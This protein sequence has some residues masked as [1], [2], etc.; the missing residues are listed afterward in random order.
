M[1]KER[2]RI[3]IMLVV[4]VG[5]LVA[6]AFAMKWFIIRAPI[7]PEVSQIGLDLRRVEACTSVGPCVTIPFKGT[8][9][10]MYPTFAMA[11]LWGSVLFGVLVGYQA[12]TRI[13]S[14]FA[15]EPLTKM[16]YMAGVSLISTAFMTGYLFAP[17]ASGTP[18]QSMGFTIEIERTWAPFMLIVAHGLGIAICFLA[19]SQSSDSGSDDVS[20]PSLPPARVLVP[21]GVSAAAAVLASQPALAPQPAPEPAPVAAMPEA[22]RGILKFA[23]IH[24]ELTAAGIDARR[25]DGSSELVMWRDVVGAVARQMPPEYDSVTFVDIVSTPGATVRVLPWT[26]LTGEPIEG[27]SEERA[28]ALLTLIEARCKEP[29]LDAATKAFVELRE[30]AAQLPDLRMLAIHDQRLGWAT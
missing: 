23:I 29:K 4:F 16:G 6:S 12:V 18:M 22:L 10:G 15:N 24:A 26:K 27:T 11:T 1:G 7:L 5:L 25:E 20:L 2:S 9:R 8:F 3:A 14:G 30:P 19:I 13:V 21:A 28:R 17:D